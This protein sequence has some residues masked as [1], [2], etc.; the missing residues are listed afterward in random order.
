M[1]Y[2]CDKNKGNFEKMKSKHQSV[3]KVLP[4]Y[5]YVDKSKLKR[6]N[7]K[8]QQPNFNYSRNH[9]VNICFNCGGKEHISKF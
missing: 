8:G 6:E 3:D 7:V 1:K 2:D 5:G 9:I 4:K